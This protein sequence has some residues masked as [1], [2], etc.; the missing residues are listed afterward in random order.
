MTNEQMLS[1]LTEKCDIYFESSLISKEQLVKKYADFF[2]SELSGE[3]RSVSIALHTGSVCFEI[4]SLITAALGCLLFDATTPEQII[5][6]LNIGDM[7][8]YENQRYRWL[9]TTTEF[10]NLHFA[11]EQDAVGKNGP[12]KR[13]ILYEA[14]KHRVRPYSG[15]SEKTDGRGIKRYK[16]NRSDFISYIFDVSSSEIPSVMGVSTVIVMERNEFYRIA[17]GIDIVYAKDKQIGLLDIAP[18]AYYTD[19]G[20]EY[21]Y[22][23]NPA[24]AEPVLKVT[25]KISTARDLVL[26]KHGNKA[27]GLMIISSDALAKGGTELKELLERKSLKFAHISAGIDSNGAENLVRTQESAM[28]FACTRKFLLQNSLP[29]QAS[30][31]LTNELA[32]QV[33]NIVHNA[34]TMEIIDGACSW[35]DFRKAKEALYIIKRADW[36]EEL[37]KRFV[38]SA[39]SLLNLFATAVFPIRKLEKAVESGQIAAI[40]FSPAVRIREL[41]ELSDKSGITNLQCAYI[42]ELLERLY[43]SYSDVCPKYDRLKQLLQSQQRKVAIIVP[44][45]YYIDILKREIGLHRPN[46]TFVTSNQFDNSKSYDEIIVVG[47][48]TGKRFDPLKCRAATD[49]IVFLYEC[50]THWFKSKIRKAR[51]FEKELNSRMGIF[52][53]DDAVDDGLSDNNLPEAE[54]AIFEEYEI[55]LKQFINK[56]NTIDIGR[57]TVKAT[58]S[59]GN[60]PISEVCSI[61]RFTTGEQILFSK[62]YKAVIFDSANGTVNESNTDDLTPGD[63]LVFA[64]RDDYTR[65]MVDFIYEKLQANELLK[66]DVLEATEKAVYWKEALRKYGNVN[67]LSYREIAK[68]LQKLGSSLQEMTVRQW[69]IEESHIVGPRD[70]KT[71]EQIAELTQD[72][73]LLQD[74]HGY[75]KACRVVR[76]QRKEILELIGRAITD[77]LIGHMPPKGSLLETVY[78]NVENLSEILELESVSLLD[79]P[80][81]VPINLIN[82]PIAE[83][84]VSA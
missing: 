52:D 31:I 63:L 54:I 69:L 5:D 17:K 20:E 32:K 83:W 45:V 75:Y 61:G 55:D 79:E 44:K 60:S 51:N 19:S 71:L 80:A 68:A 46:Y 62:Y 4:I 59:A 65:N 58:D 33:G 14:N 24:K 30:N 28:L 39:Y 1:A 78:E 12:L 77:K 21:Q 41:R 16:N 67:N 48:F 40:I 56:T 23:N 43:K 6:A 74:T 81:I 26:D 34:V 64:K 37:K 29:S 66:S 3:E 73:C 15:E 9:G 25:G 57:F 10:G 35:D 22:G 76:R 13:Y 84:E 47:D 36:N 49:I 27:V 8:L 72:A 2:A 42:T 38:I 7:V 18:A 53:Y 70:E 82:K 11:L 50:E